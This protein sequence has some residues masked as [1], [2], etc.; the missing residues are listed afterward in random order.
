M[1][2]ADWTFPDWILDWRRRPPGV[3]EALGRFDMLPAV[4]LERILGRWRGIGLPTGHPLDGQLENLGWWGKDLAAVEGVHPL[5]FRLSGRIVAVDPARLPVRIALTCPRL[6]RSGLG[7][8][9][10]RLLSPWMRT[11]APAARLRQ[12]AFRGRSSAAMVYDRQ[13][14]VDHFRADGQDRLLGLMEMEGMARPYF[15]ALGRARAIPVRPME[16]CA[17]RF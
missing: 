3:A 11:R 10:F 12:I 6:G 9:G 17:E 8:V 16:S 15:F 7:A 2:S 14:I 1:V 4:R 13:P 5:L